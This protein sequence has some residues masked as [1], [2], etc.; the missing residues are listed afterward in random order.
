MG[1]GAWQEVFARFNGPFGYEVRDLNVT[2]GELDFVRSL[3]HVNGTMADGQVI[4]R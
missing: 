2:D 1:N 4:D 3:N